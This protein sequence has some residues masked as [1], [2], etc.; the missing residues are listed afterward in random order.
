[1]TVVEKKAIYPWDGSSYLFQLLHVPWPYQNT[2]SLPI[3]SYSTYILQYYT[4][5][6]QLFTYFYNNPIYTVPT[7][8]VV[9]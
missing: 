7:L 4:E 6:F 1:M 2:C 5:K 9:Q 8:A 3:V